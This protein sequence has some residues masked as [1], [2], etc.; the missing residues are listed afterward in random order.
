MA[1]KKNG[2]KD[3]PGTIGHDEEGRPIVQ[4]P[5]GGILVY[6]KGA[7]RQP[8]AGRPKEVVKLQARKDYGKLRKLLVDKA[9]ADDLSNGEML[10]W[11]Q[12]AAD[13]GD[14][15]DPMKIDPS[16]V[17]RLAEHV[18]AVVKDEDDLQEIFQ[19]W[20]RELGALGA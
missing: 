4:Q 18:Q 14:L 13:V 1:G 2:K 12:I 8:G 9:E 7:G 3:P 5:H 11:L 10:R 20:A 19:R 17:S 16:I 15:R 6:G